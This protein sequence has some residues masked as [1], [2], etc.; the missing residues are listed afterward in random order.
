MVAFVLLGS[1]TLEMTMKNINSLSQV[2]F[3]S[4]AN[5]KQSAKPV[6]SVST[7]TIDIKRGSNPSNSNWKRN[8]RPARIN[9]HLIIFVEDNS[10]PITS[11][12]ARQARITDQPPVEPVPHS[13]SIFKRLPDEH[14]ARLYS[15]S[16]GFINETSKE[17]S[18]QH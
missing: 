18:P 9:H 16:T 5:F 13:L 8:E 3:K 12:Q 11:D 1:K 14:S 17:V 10:G 4:I 15:S 7:A 2:C 6:T